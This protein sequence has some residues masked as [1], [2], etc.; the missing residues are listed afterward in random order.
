VFKGGRLWTWRTSINEFEKFVGKWK[1]AS[2]GKTV[3]K[4]GLKIIFASRIEDSNSRITAV[5]VSGI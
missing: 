5:S 2:I 3:L 1:N 4:E